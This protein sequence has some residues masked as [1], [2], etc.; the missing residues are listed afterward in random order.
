MALCAVGIVLLLVAWQAAGDVI[1]CNTFCGN[2]P[3][4]FN[5]GCTWACNSTVETHAAC[6]EGCITNYYQVDNSTR[7]DGC[8]AGCS[9]R[10]V[11]ACPAPAGSGVGQPATE[12]AS[13][14]ADS[15]GNVFVSPREGAQTVVG[16]LLRVGNTLVRALEGG[17]VVFDSA[18]LVAN[19]VNATH[20]TAQ[21]LEAQ[22]WRL[23]ANVFVQQAPNG[24]LVLGSPDGTMVDG[25]SVQ[26]LI[27]LIDQ[28]Q[29][30]IS[31]LNAT[32]ATLRRAS[33]ISSELS[34][35]IYNLHLKLGVPLR[36]IRTID[37]TGDVGL[38]VSL[39]LTTSGFPV[40][41]YHDGTNGD[42]KLAV[43]ADATCSS[44]TVIRTI[45]SAGNVGFYTSLALTA[46]GFPVIS[47]YDLTNLDL[48]LAVCADATCSSG[49]IIRTIDSTGAVGSDTSLA[50]T[51]AGFPVIS[52]RDGTNGDLKLAVCADATCS[53][54]TV[55]RTIDSAG[56]VGSDTSLALTS[57]DFPVISYYD[58]TNKHL[59]LA[60]CGAATCSSSTTIRTIDSTGDV[61]LF[62]SLALT[63]AGF[64]VISYYDIANQDL[65]L[66]V[67][68]DATCSSGITIR[69]IDST[70]DVGRFT[71]LALTPAGLPVISYYD[72]TNGD[73]KLAVCADA[74]CSSATTIRT[75]DSTGAVG[76]Y[77]SLALTTAGFPVIAYRDITNS[78]Y[79]LK[80]A[81][82]TDTT[83]L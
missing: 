73:L 78:V 20:L 23:S 19:Q 2:L 37:S 75:I 81:V 51:T 77:T 34:T 30:T 33:V 15:A 18:T 53:S 70:G 6:L 17:Q 50:L 64:P 69:T 71:S 14:H 74:M 72:L 4:L 79:D 58:A 32:V 16:P 57:A 7:R 82:C 39:A 26:Q 8:F 29:S 49:T 25:V 45:D 9:Q 47:Y 76:Q 46:A 44:G 66:A 27:A 31:E 36:T 28:Q 59:K 13:I 63:T 83:C 1:A 56:A 10:F 55:I 41:S 35:A 62:T 12:G 42:L 43:C 48:K 61:G 65:K 68:G 5:N 54:G 11:G 38:F 80:L 24:S 40:I 52:Y 21:V 67:C 22:S 3:P 60:V